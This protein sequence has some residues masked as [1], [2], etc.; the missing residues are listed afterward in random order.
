VVTLAD[1]E[2]N[3]TIPSPVLN[4]NYMASLPSRCVVVPIID[5]DNSVGPCQSKPSTRISELV[6]QLSED[7]HDENNNGIQEVHEFKIV[8]KNPL[9]VF[10]DFAAAGVLANGITIEQAATKEDF[11]AGISK[12]IVDTRSE[13]GGAPEVSGSQIGR[14]G[15]DNIPVFNKLFMDEVNSSFGV[16]VNDVL[17][18]TRDLVSAT[19][20]RLAPIATSPRGFNVGVKGYGWLQRVVD[21]SRGEWIRVTVSKGKG[22]TSGLYNLHLIYFAEDVGQTNFN[23]SVSTCV[24]TPSSAY[25]TGAIENTWQAVKKKPKVRNGILGAAAGAA[26]VTAAGTTAVAGLAGTAVGSI[27]PAAAFGVAFAPAAAVVAVGA[28]P[29]ALVR[30]EFFCGADKAQSPFLDQVAVGGALAQIFTG[31]G[32]HQP[33]VVQGQGVAGL[34]EA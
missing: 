32:V 14:Y 15:V 5:I 10:F 6:T 16:S 26:A 2:D 13:A 33:Q 4:A 19:G 12:L 1:P 30:L 21:C 28:E 3:K 8:G 23:P 7:T 34:V 29:I 17:A 27:L 11:D 18:N 9:M 24:A 31:Y 20:D 25:V 22:N